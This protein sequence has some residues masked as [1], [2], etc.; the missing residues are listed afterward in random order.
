[1]L[2]TSRI[3]WWKCGQLRT[4]SSWAS[5]SE[6]LRSPSGR[7]GDR[8]PYS[9]G[10]GYGAPSSYQIIDVGDV[11]IVEVAP[12][13]LRTFL[14]Q[15]GFALEIFRDLRSDVE[16]TVESEDV[17]LLEAVV[18]RNGV[19]D[20]NTVRN[21][22]MHPAFGIN[23]LGI[24]RRGNRLVTGLSQLVLQ[25]GDVLLIQGRIEVVQA[26][27]PQLGLLS[28]RSARVGC[29]AT[30]PPAGSHSHFRRRPP[31]HHIRR[32][33]DPHIP[34]GRGCPAAGQPL[35]LTS[36]CISGGQLAHHHP[37]GAR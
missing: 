3:T 16:Q 2:S 32:R 5:S 25:V 14:T 10:K 22:H 13:D 12:E 23:L 27:L 35:P 20:G 36:G 24:S 37:V 17:T 1:M 9:Q 30:P 11:F 21:I 6:T 28:P 15:T 4:P 8:G 29:R 31:A 18:M 33:P 19:A 34:A 7:C 26:A